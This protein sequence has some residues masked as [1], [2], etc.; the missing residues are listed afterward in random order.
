MAAVKAFSLLDCWIHLAQNINYSRLTNGIKSVFVKTR[1]WTL[2]ESQKTSFDVNVLQHFS[3]SSC[4]SA[5]LNKQKTRLANW[6]LSSALWKKWNA[7]RAMNTRKLQVHLKASRNFSTTFLALWS[8]HAS[9]YRSWNP[10]SRSGK[11]VRVECAQKKASSLIS[12]ILITTS[13]DEISQLRTPR[14][15]S[16]ANTSNELKK[17]GGVAKK[18][19]LH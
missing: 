1:Q 10:F 16:Y 7:G 19:W 14:F 2:I 5:S 9:W 4:K 13:P 6:W 15:S 18:P 12:G 8:F 17:P 3:I 11:L